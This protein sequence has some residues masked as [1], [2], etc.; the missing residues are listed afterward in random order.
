MKTL[1][2][3]IASGGRPVADI[4]EGYLDVK[5]CILANLALIRLGGRLHLGPK[6]GKSSATTKL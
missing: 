1:L 4:E 6:A 2:A 3:A 5:R